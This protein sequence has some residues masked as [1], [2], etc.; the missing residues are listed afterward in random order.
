LAYYPNWYYYAPSR[1]YYPPSWT[2][3]AQND[4]GTEGGKI[5]GRS[6]TFYFKSLGALQNAW[7]VVASG[8]FN[9]HVVMSRIPINKEILETVTKVGHSITAIFALVISYKYSPD[10][11]THKKLEHLHETLFNLIASLQDT[12][13]L[14]DELQILFSAFTNF[15][16][17]FSLWSPC[18]SAKHM[19]LYTD[20]VLLNAKMEIMT[21]KMNE[22]CL[23]MKSKPD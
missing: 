7:I 18:I 20:F 10:D 6:F 4:S 22:V 15:Q 8:R 17:N 13:G 11:K 5:D 12:P 23:T 19:L 14:D 1:R 2:S 16:T 3:N 21:A 9:A